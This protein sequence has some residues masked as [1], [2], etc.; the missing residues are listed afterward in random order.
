MR[1]ATIGAENGADIRTC[2][3]DHGS[4]QPAVL[5]HGYRSTR[6]PGNV[7][8]ASCWQPWNRV[9]AYDRRGFG[10]SSRPTLS[11]QDQHQ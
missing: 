9:I 1:Y 11:G 7:R 6:T 3:E 10:Q 5:I 4:G 8:N 2:Y